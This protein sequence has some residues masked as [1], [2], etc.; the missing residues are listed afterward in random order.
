MNTLYTM[1]K[2]DVVVIPVEFNVILEQE[3][4]S[5]G[6][7]V[8]KRKMLRYLI[9][10]S[11]S[12]NFYCIWDFKNVEL[13]DDRMFDELV[14]EEISNVIIINI[15]REKIYEQ[16]IKSLEDGGKKYKSYERRLIFSKKTKYLIDSLDEKEIY[17]EHVQEIVKKNTHEYN[18]EW[19]YLVSSG[20][21]S[22]MMVDLKGMLYNHVDTIYIIYSLYNCISEW[23]ENF[24][25][26][27]AT[28]KNGVA[29]A[30]ILCEIFQKDLIC[31]NIGQMFEEIYNRKPK[32]EEGKKYV[33]IFDVI[34]L[35]SEAKVV[36]ALITAQGG[37]LKKSFGVIC[38]Q[39]LQAIKEKNRYSFLNHVKP[40]ITYEEMDIDYKI[41]L[42]GE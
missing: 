28:S 4:Y 38:L 32:I 21:Y 7:F 20:V 29:L 40:L 2:S 10:Y 30:S 1:K 36:N 23:D 24:D 17:R 39:N 42:S 34:C 16:L 37:I 25:Y 3:D 13:C 5:F 33:H 14:N 26:F 35:G 15:E 19:E 11:K 41:S 6:G 22:N 8:L 31:F 12:V 18:G 9:D 27:V